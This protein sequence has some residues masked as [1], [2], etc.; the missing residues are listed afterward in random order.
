MPHLAMNPSNSFSSR[1]TFRHFSSSNSNDNQEMQEIVDL[2]K[3]MQ[4]TKN[5]QQQHLVQSGKR[6]QKQKQKQKR[7]T[8]ESNGEGEDEDAEQQD[9][10]DEEYD[11][12]DY[13]VEKLTTDWLKR[14]VIGL[15]L[16]P[17][18]DKPFRD[19]KLHIKVIR[20]NDPEVLLGAIV[21]EALQRV[22]QPGTTLVVAPECF[23]DDF[24]SYLEVVQAFEE[25]ILPY[26]LPHLHSDSLEGIIQ[27]APFHPYFEFQGSGSDGIDNY[28]NR[29]PYP[30]FHIL[31]EEEV[32]WAVSKLGGDASRVWQRNV[33]L[34][35]D[36][37]D[38]MGRSN[39]EHLFDVSS[40]KPI[41][42]NL[43]QI[44]ARHRLKMTSS[45]N[46]EEE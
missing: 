22:Q 21:Y 6:R 2:I 32:E 42:G 11:P 14:I 3:E 37:D 5:K 26:P 33:D 27:V 43:G 40:D 28:T 1:S 8:T 30:I 9:I 24:E 46:H 10:V 25:D 35:E 41:K 39:V 18:A 4:Q 23:P 38:T 31:R 44:L 20:G 15:N 16:C 17:F 13:V 19:D 36:L 12:P 45:S 7:T 29:S 34:L